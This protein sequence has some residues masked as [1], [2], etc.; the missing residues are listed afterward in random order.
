[1]V[2]T[3]YRDLNYYKKKDMF[4]SSITHNS[5]VVVMLLFTLTISMD[6]NYFEWLPPSNFVGLHMTQPSEYI[7]KSNLT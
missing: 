4:H 6:D 5:L 2:N 1:M 7:S 3:E